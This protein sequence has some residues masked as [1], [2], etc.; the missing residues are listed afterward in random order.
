MDHIESRPTKKKRNSSYE[1]YLEIKAKNANLAN[2]VEKLK[3]SP[4]LSNVLILDAETKIE[5][6]IWIPFSI[7]ELDNCTHLNIKYEPD[8]DSRHPVQNFNQLFFNNFL[9]FIGFF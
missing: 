9:F 3:E 5:E 1:I 8:I 7:W 4:F 6:K 2:L